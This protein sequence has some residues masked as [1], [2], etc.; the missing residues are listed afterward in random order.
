LRGKKHR[1]PP[2]TAL[3]EGPTAEGTVSHAGTQM[4]MNTHQPHSYRSLSRRINTIGSTPRDRAGLSALEFVGCLMALVG[5]VWLGAIY[6]GVDV[7]HVVFGALAE[8]DLMDKVP[9]N[10]RPADPKEANAP[11]PQ[12]LA[13]SV[14]KELI[15]LR[16]EIAALR[17][18]QYDGLAAASQEGGGQNAPTVDTQ[19]LTKLATLEYWSRLQIVVQNEI[20]LQR[21]AESAATDGNATKV[22]ALKGR[23]SRLTASAIRALPIVHVD[24]VAVT[25]A[26]DIA[27][28]YE[29]GATLYDQAVAIWESSARSSGGGQL[30]KDWE[31]AQIQHRN[32]GRLL[33]D[34]VAAVRDSLTRRFGEGFAGFSRL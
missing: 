7:R 13:E 14:Q 8:S 18:S 6:L 33:G 30:S 4:T 5:G 1:N 9:E 24:P 27:N 20:A 19:Q 25:L 26:K 3:P 31:Q 22:A 17:T 16:Q 21:D 15:A 34:Q 10:W 12:E 29:Q 32:E 23:I 11:T 2:Q 28:W